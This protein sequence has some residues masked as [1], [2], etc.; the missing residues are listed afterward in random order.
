[1]IAMK[2]GNLL[3]SLFLIAII[4][5]GI[6][7]VV[8]D[9]SDVFWVNYGFLMFAVLFAACTFSFGSKTEKLANKLNIYVVASVFLICE[10]IAAFVCARF[11]SAA[12]ALVVHLAVIGLFIIFL[13]MTLSGNAHVEQ[14][15]AQRGMDLQNFKT[16]LEKFKGVQKNVPYSAP[17]KKIVEKAFD[18]VA[19]GQVTGS[20]EVSGI[21]REISDAVDELGKAVS[22]GD[23]QAIASVCTKIG[24]LAADRESKLKLRSNF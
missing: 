24:Q 20:P 14:Q 4:N 18:A 17:Y 22:A 13:Y 15:Q 1:V 5:I 7:A 16:V 10:A 9:R 8:N 23:E 2:K 6:F 11:D 19:S 12:W 3:V 21:E